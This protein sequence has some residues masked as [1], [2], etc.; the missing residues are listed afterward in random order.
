LSL[1]YLAWVLVGPMGS[2]LKLGTV[3]PRIVGVIS[4]VGQQSLAVFVFSM[5]LARLLGV[6]L[7]ELSTVNDNG[8]LIR[9]PWS[10]AVVNLIGFAMIIGVAYGAA[11][12][13]SQPW[14][15]KQ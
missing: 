8:R 2:R 5:L 15:K 6:A 12:Y 13:K 9:D 1:A 11:W 7:D 4:K 3:W 10:N 14:R